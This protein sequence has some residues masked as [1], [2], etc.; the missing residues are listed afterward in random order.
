MP[1]YTRRAVL[2][3]GATALLSAC[4][5]TIPPLPAKTSDR[6]EDLTRDQ[7]IS[8]INAVR[9]ANGAGAWSYNGQLEAAAR[10]QARLM[11]SKDTLSHNL[12]VTLRQR[13][14]E[15]GYVYAVGEN[16]AKGYKTLPTTIE[17]WLASQGH[18][19]T[20]LSNRFTEFGL[21]FARTN[22]GKL[23][24]ALIAGGPFEAWAQA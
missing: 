15:A 20:L 11:A 14:T 8:T 19:N 22:S 13:V 10:S 17:G 23:Y 2:A 12:G 6:P 9:R 21:A 4:A 16:V 18:R 1:S 5:S 24:W 7:I 3:L